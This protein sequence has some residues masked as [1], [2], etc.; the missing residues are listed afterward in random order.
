[1]RPR[2]RPRLTADVLRDLVEVAAGVH[3]AT[4]AVYTTTSTVVVGPDGSCLVVDPAR[5]RARGGRPRRDDPRARL[6]ARRRL[7]DARA[8]GP[9]ARRSR[10]SRTCPAGRPASRPPTA[11]RSPRNGTPTPSSPANGGPP[12]PIAAAATAYPAAVPRRARLARPDRPGPRPRR[13]R[14]T[15]HRPL[16]ARTPACS[17]R[18]TCSPT[19]RSRCWT[20]RRTT[21]SATTC[22]RSTLLE[23]TGAERRRPR[24][25]AGRDATSADVLAADRAYLSG[26]RR[27]CDTADERRAL[28]LDRRRPRRAAGGR[29]TMTGM[30]WL[31]AGAVVTLALML[32]AVDRMMAR[33][34]FDRRRPRER[35]PTGAWVAPGRSVRS[36]TCSSPTASTSPPSR[37]ASSSTSS[38]PATRPGGS[39]STRASSAWTR[40]RRRSNGSRVSVLAPSVPCMTPVVSHLTIDAA[41]PHA[42]ARWWRDVL[43]WS[44][45]WEPADGRRRDRHRARRRRR[46]RL[47]VHQGPRRQ[48]RQ[49]PPAR[50]PASAERLRPAHRARPPALARRH[51]RRHRAGRRPLARAGGPRG[52]RVLPA[53][54]HPRP[55]RRSPRRAGVRHL[56]VPPHG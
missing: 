56:I 14:A 54:Q 26:A 49:E 12:A 11:R 44:Y 13:A 1:M 15:A 23:A 31:I 47:A 20:C 48:G 45:V 5:D 9:R 18:A 16:P 42:L 19:S 29:G 22:A 21:P 27:R 41:D 40:V 36:S 35:R 50:R 6:D 28:A 10:A 37:T 3:V 24:A 25:R 2:W 51:P 53:A 34:W 55:A 7:V 4:S 33:G 17:W 46:D 8:L 52:Q 39:T 30:G 32:V 38:R 43:G